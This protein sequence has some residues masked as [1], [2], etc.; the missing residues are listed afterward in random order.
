MFFQLFTQ[1]VIKLCSSTNLINQKFSD[2]AIK[3][4]IEVSKCCTCQ[5]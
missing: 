1:V 4:A 5:L 2:A 3:L